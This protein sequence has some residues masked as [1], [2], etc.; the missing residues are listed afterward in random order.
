M[1]DIIYCST[2]STR[3]AKPA[4]GPRSCSGTILAAVAIGRAG[5]RPS[6][7]FAQRPTCACRRIACFRVVSP[8]ALLVTWPAR[9]RARAQSQAWPPRRPAGLRC[10]STQISHS[11]N[12]CTL[13]PQATR[14]VH[15]RTGLGGVRPALRVRNLLEVAEHFLQRAAF[16]LR[17]VLVHEE[18]AEPRQRSQ[19]HQLHRPQRVSFGDKPKS[20]RTSQAGGGE[21]HDA[22]I[23]E[24]LGHR[25]ER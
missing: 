16:G 7:A 12:P 5:A 6:P 20:S 8:R 11:Q 18:R 19:S 4:P 22:D 14:A 17:Q 10:T 2:G 1:N 23:G 13:K 3:Q 25:Q 15:L 21:T 9:L 24:E